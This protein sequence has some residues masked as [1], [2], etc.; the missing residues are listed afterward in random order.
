MDKKLTILDCTLRDGGY[1][2]N[3]QFNL[4]DANGR[5]THRYGYVIEVLVPS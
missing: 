1:Y 4:K 2:N 5:L 3:W